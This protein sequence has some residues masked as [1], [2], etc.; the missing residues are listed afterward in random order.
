M[1]DAAILSLAA[2]AFRTAVFYC[3][4]WTMLGCSGFKEN[5]ELDSAMV[6]VK[7]MK[8]D[9]DNSITD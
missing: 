4:G 8:L 2:R 9:T 3:V 5:L 6:I 7:R 1:V